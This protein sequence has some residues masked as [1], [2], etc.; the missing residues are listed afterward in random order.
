MPPIMPQPGMPAQGAMPT[1]PAPQGQAPA[2]TGSGSVPQANHGNQA[3]AMIAVQNAVKMLEQ[4][5]PMIPMGSPLHEKIHKVALELSKELTQGEDNP[6]L[7]MQ[8]LVQMMR[9][10]SQQQPMNALSK[11]SAPPPNTPPATM[12]GGETPPPTAGA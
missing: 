2:H 10:A 11:L 7:Q 9:H 12:P 6:A 5:L 1:A 8:S 4:A 3:Q